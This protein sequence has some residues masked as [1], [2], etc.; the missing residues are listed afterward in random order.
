MSYKILEK[1]PASISKYCWSNKEK[2]TRVI[3]NKTKKVFRNGL[4]SL[5]PKNKQ[6][7]KYDKKIT[8]KNDVLPYSVIKIL[9]E[10][11]PQKPKKFVTSKLPTNLPN[12]GSFGL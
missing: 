11:A 5:I 9:E 1:I 7:P 8:K 2:L 6:T 12:P 10:I 3:A 4:F